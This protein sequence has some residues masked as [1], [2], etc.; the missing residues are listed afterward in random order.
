MTLSKGEGFSSVEGVLQQFEHEP[1]VQQ[2]HNMAMVYSKSNPPT[3]LVN[4]AQ[5]EIFKNQI[6]GKMDRELRKLK[7]G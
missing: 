5:I 7:Y 6:N 2:V 4:E 3:F 1:N